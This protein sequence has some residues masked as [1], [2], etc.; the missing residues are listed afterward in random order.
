[1]IKGILKIL[2]FFV[3]FA[4]FFDFWTKNYPGTTPMDLINNILG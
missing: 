2:I 4:F 1:M 3:L